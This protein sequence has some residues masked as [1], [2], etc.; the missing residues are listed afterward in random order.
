MNEIELIRA[1]LD[2]E[3]SHAGAVAA[4][5]A[6]ALGHAA[7]AALASG[8]PLETF[9]Q[10]CVDY[11]VCVL[12]WFEERDRRLA[13]LINQYGP[14]HPTRDALD[15]ALARRGRSREAL[16]KLEAAF[17]AAPD[18]AAAAGARQAWAEFAQFFSGTWSTRRDALDALLS[19]N[20][21]AS[22]WRHMSGVDADTILEERGR[23]AHVTE[24]LPPG[25]TLGAPAGKAAP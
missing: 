1:Q 11:L 3:R 13:G 2:L 23:Y 14:E 7:P 4:A 20:S 5:T 24:T 16:E 25:V 17:A 9:R 18:T 21:R 10:A 6:V 12:A 8:T 22:D 15:A 19:A